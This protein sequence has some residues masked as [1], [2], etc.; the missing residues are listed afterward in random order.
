[1]SNN[2]LAE[3]V[4]FTGDY[5]YDCTLLQTV[6]HD[7]FQKELECMDPDLKQ[8]LVALLL[9]KSFRY[10][11]E[12]VFKLAS[13]KMSTY[14]IDCR[15]TTHS[16][17]GKHIIGNLILDLI[18]DTD[19]Q[20]VGGLTMGADPIACSVSYAAHERGL[21]IASFS[22]RKEPKAHG[23][24]QQVEGDV[25]EG[26]RVFILEDVVTTG[27]STIKAIEAAR[28]EGLD[29]LGVV[30]LVD[31]EEGGS[32]EIQKHVQNLIALCTKAELLKACGA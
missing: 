10:N 8:K 30:A 24:R 31:R 3:Q 32:A 22:I 2:D 9:E 11:P 16:C 5:W 13:G 12:P 28:R 17:A 23:M 19:V 26:D 6:A 7:Y 1:M 4:V 29:V 18:V 27:G 15:K 21:D 14:Y 25:K 20:A